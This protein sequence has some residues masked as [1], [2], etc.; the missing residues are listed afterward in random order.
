MKSIRFGGWGDGPY[1]SRTLIEV[2][3]LDQD[4]V[5]EAE[6]ANGLCAGRRDRRQVMA[7]I[8]VAPAHR[9][10]ESGRDD[11]HLQLPLA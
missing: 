6:Q 7:T 10:F 2:H 8:A 1:P 3:R 5:V 4:D 9:N 11:L